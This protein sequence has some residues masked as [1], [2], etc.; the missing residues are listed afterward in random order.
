MSSVKRYLKFLI[1][2]ILFG[3]SALLFTV[4]GRGVSAYASVQEA[5]FGGGNG[6]QESPYIIATS[7]DLLELLNDVNTHVAPDGYFNY[8]FRFD[9]DIDLTGIA[10]EPI[11][12]F[13]YPFKGIVDG[14]G[15]SVTGLTI[16]NFE[17]SYVGLFGVLSSSAKVDGLAVFGTV[18]G[19]AEIGG[20]SGLNY[21]EITNCQSGATV[22]SSDDMSSIDIGGICGY[23]R[24]LIGNSFNV[25]NIVSHGLN[26]GGIV[27]INGEDG[28]VVGCFNV[29]DVVSDYY[30]VGGIS[31]HNDGRIEQCFN[32]AP[33]KGY[34]TIGGISGSNTGSIRY[35]YNTASVSAADNMAGGVCGSNEGELKSCY[36][37]GTPT[38]KN[39]KGGICGYNAPESVIEKCFF[40][41]DKFIGHVTGRNES[42]PLCDGLRD[43]EMASVDTLQDENKLGYIVDGSS[44]VWMKRD[45]DDDCCYYPELVCF[46]GSA[47]EAVGNYSRESARISRRAAEVRLGLISCEYDGTEHKSDVW[48]GQERLTETNDY[49]CEYTDNVN[50]GTASVKVTLT[51]YYFGESV[52]EFE[53]TKKPIDIEWDDHELIYDGRVLHPVVAKA[54]GVVPGDDVEF[55]YSVDGGINVGRHKVTAVLA[56]GGINENYYLAPQSHKYSISPRKLSVHWDEE[57]LI[58]NK[59]AQYPM[60]QICDGLVNDDRVELVYSGYTGNIDAGKGYKVTVAVSSRDTNYVLHAT[61]EYAIAPKPIRANFGFAIFN[62][63]GKCQYPKIE[64]VV[65]LAFGDSVVFEYYG[66]ENNIDIGE[67]TVYAELSDKESGT[68]YACER[69]SCVYEIKQG[70]FD[71]DSIT[72]S[73]KSFIFDGTEK[74]LYIEGELPA[75]ITVS[76]S[77]NSRTDVGQ[78][79]V[80]ASFAIKEDRYLYV[81]PI[82]AVLTICP[83]A[84]F[85]DGFEVG[86]LEGNVEYGAE[87]HVDSFEPNKKFAHAKTVAAYRIGFLRNGDIVSSEGR[88]TIRIPLDSELIGNKRIKLHT[89]HNGIASVV[90]F[91]IV[92]GF[93]EFETDNLEGV[94]YLTYQESYLFILWIVL[95][96]LLFASASGVSLILIRKRKRPVVSGERAAAV[97]VDMT[98][99]ENVQETVPASERTQ[100]ENSASDCDFYI[101]GVYCKSYDSFI[102]SL[103]YKNI[104][105]QREVCGTDAAHAIACSVGKGGDKRKDLYWQG[106]RIMRDS[107]E[108]NAFIQKVKSQIIQK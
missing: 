40:S 13:T 4:M 30:S 97:A 78:Y 26:S 86:V 42:Y 27:G 95:G 65:G 38:A 83:N 70:I 94:F 67:H 68:N 10:F 28:Q 54:N 101:D 24:G 39:T 36:N 21:G 64:D 59:K 108:Y 89:E 51:N 88:F 22:V 73:S 60:A 58:Y 6:K 74:S 19:F 45:Y 50:A 99:S 20:I 79:I 15:K 93:I 7:D 103:N 3:I 75:D 37:A 76:Y 61:K 72:F 90:D 25:G 11:G 31:G 2:A 106:K 8:Y 12:D 53:I 81:E 71:I 43:F 69:V 80:T 105:R 98:V 66:Y 87:L 46:Y 29:G 23:N 104:I 100:E 5:K 35:S 107:E 63:T 34:A 96:I 85:S 57:A 102:A 77:G 56:H 17:L 32:N 18:E 91:K 44:A 9:E 1:V 84:Y 92:D 48:L 62:Y 47:T 16:G 49:V 33:I 55:D 41:T 82:T 52:K 14:N